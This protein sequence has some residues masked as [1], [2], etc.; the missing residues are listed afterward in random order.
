MKF[1]QLDEFEKD[2]KRLRKKYRSLEDDLDIIKKVLAVFPHARPPFS[3]RMDGFGGS[4]QLIKVRKIACMSMKGKG[5]NSGLRMIY[6]WRSLENR[7]T[8]IE[9]Y[10]KGEKENEDSERIRRFYSQK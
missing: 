8:L 4:I 10:F 7:I 6:D 2:L 3:F 5:V 9:L 1:E